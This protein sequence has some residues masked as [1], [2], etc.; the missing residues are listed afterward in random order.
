LQKTFIKIRLYSLAA[1]ASCFVL[2]SITS[3]SF[4]QGRDRSKFQYIIDTSTARKDTTSSK[5]TTAAKQPIDSTAR[6]K[7]FKFVREDIP[8]PSFGTY[9]SPFFLTRTQLVQKTITF[10]SLNNVI[11]S[12]TFDGEQI[13][14]H[15]KIPLDQYLEAKSNFTLRDRMYTIVSE[16]YKIETKDELEKLFKN[17]TDITI[18]LPFTT[19]TIFGPPTINLKINGA[20]DITASYQRNSSDQ[21]TI[22]EVSPTQNNINFKQEVQ[23]TTKGSI[24]DK[25][26]ID[27]D[28]NSQ[29]TFDYE[30]QLKL[31]YTGYPD[32]VIQSLE[33]GN[34][35]LETKS[36][37]IG[38]TQALFGIKGQFKLGPLTLTAI[39]SQK[40]SEKKEVDITGGSQQVNFEIPAYQY[41]DNN[42][43]LDT[44]YRPAFEEYY[45][46]GLLRTQALIYKRIAPDIEVWVQTTI[47]N[48]NRRKAVCWIDLPEKQG[49]YSQKW[50]SQDTGQIDGRKFTGY[51]YKLNPGDFTLHDQ[52]GYI[53]LNVNLPAAPNDAVAVAYR[54]V[55]NTSVQYGDYSADPV[56][57]DSLVL[58]LVRF[59]GL[60]PPTQ[61]TAQRIA[62]NMKIKNIYSVGVRNIRNDP[63]KFSFNVYYKPPSGDNQPNIILR[64]STKSYLQLTKLDLR[65]NGSN[66]DPTGQVPDGAFDFFSGYTIDLTA[67]AV[68]FPTLSP[69]YQTL[70]D[71]GV[72]DSLI[73]IDTTIY[74][75]SKTDAQNSSIKFY[76]GGTA[77]GDASSRYSLG[78][79]VVEGSVKVFN[80]SVQLIQGVDF[81]IDYSTGELVITNAGVL[82]AG[83]NLKIQYE[84]NDL[85]QLASKT[86]LGT[87]LEYAFNKTSYAG[88]TLLNLKQQTLNDK[89]RIGEE[90]TNNTILGFDAST[91]IKTN[92]LT[93][94]M[95]KIPGYN[96]K[97]ESILN[98]KGE[99]AVMLPDPNTKKSIIPGDNGESVAYID[100]FEGSKKIIDLGLNPLA[101]TVSSLPLDSTIISDTAMARRRC[102]FEWFNIVNNVLVTDVYPNRQ[103][104]SSSNNTLT[105]LALNINPYIPGMYSYIDSNKFIS[106]DQGNPRK[107][108]TGIFKYLNTSQTN[109]L[110]ENMGFIEIWM[111]I[112]TLAPTDSAKMLIDLG[113]VTEKIIADP[114]IPFPINPGRSFHTEDKNNNGLLEQDEDNGIDGLSTAEELTATTGDNLGPDPSRDDYSWNQNSTDYSHFNG[115][116]G[117]ST[118]NKRIDS[119]DMNGNGVLDE[120]NNYWEYQ[121]PLNRDTTHNKYITGGGN[122]NWYQYRIPLNDVYKNYGNATTLTNVQYVRVW[123]KGFTQ[124]ASLRIVEISLVG[125]QWQ[126]T[127][128]NDTSYSI[129]VVNIEENP[130]TYMSPVGGNVLRQTDPSSLDPN[131][132]QNEQSMSLDVRK[133]YQGQGKFATKFFNSKPID[134]LNYKILKLFV[135]GEPS[136]RYTDTARFDAS[137][138]IRLG[139]DSSN[140]YEYRAPIHPDQR[141]GQPWNTLNEVSINLADLTQV[142][143]FRDTISSIPKYIRDV[144][145]PPGA[146]YGILGDPTITNITQISLGVINNHNSTIPYPITGSVWF[147]EMRVLKT[148]DKSGYAYNVSAALKV[149][150]FGNLNFSYSKVDPNFHTLEDRFGNRIN[151]NSW[152]FSG[153][154]NLHKVL[155]SLL[156]SWLSLKFK[157]FFTIPFSFDHSESYAKPVYLPNTDIDMETAAQN[158]YNSVIALD[159]NNPNIRTYA[160]YLSDQVRIASQTLTVSNRFAVTGMK[161][162]LPSDNFFVQEML[163]KLEI[164]FYRNSSTERNPVS[165]SRYL[166]DM[167]GSIGMTSELKL[168]DQFN[169]SIGKF[170][171][172]GDDYKNAK[173]YF[174]FPF[175]P[176]MPLFSNNLT[177]G[178]NFTRNHGDEQLR[179]Q[180]QP[181]PTTRNFAANRNFS[182]DWKF[183][184]N[185]IVDLTGNYSFNAGSDLTYLEVTND[186]LRNQRSNSQILKDI[187]FHNALIN[188][189]KDLNYTQAININ[190]K[191]NIPVLKNFADLTTSYRSQYGWTP[192]LSS[193]N[194]GSGVGFSTDFQSSIY[195][196]LKQ[197]FDLFKGSD[198]SNK[199]QGGSN[200]M[201][202]NQE[203]NLT[204]V[205]KLLRTFLPDGLSFTFSQSHTVANGGVSGRAGFANFWTYWGTKENYGPSRLYQLGWVNYPGTR[206]PNV[207]LQDQEGLTNS[208]NI[209]TFINPIFPNNLKINFTYKT[210]W[211]N[212]KQSGYTTDALGNLTDG[213]GNLGVPSTI[214]NVRTITRPS[215]IFGSNIVNNLAKPDPFSMTKADEIANSFEKS[216]VSFPFPS[217]TITLN[218]IER[219]EMFQ[220]FATSISFENSYS[221]DYKKTLQFNGNAPEYIASQSLTSGFTPLIGINVAFKQI[222]GGNLTASFKLNKTNNYDLTP[223]SLVINNTNTTDL[224]IN[225]SYSKSGFKIPL[226]GLS[227]DNDISI[228][229]SYTRTNNDPRTLKYDSGIWSDDAQ[230]SGS[231]STA[232]N[233][234]IQYALSKNVSI[235]VFY[236]YTKIAPTQGSLQIP[237]TTSNEA[238][239][240]IKLTIQ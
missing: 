55:N 20:I 157:D 68:I 185:W 22:T 220:S 111:R 78:F 224:A 129:S 18:P 172:L 176:A 161:F 33:A 28:W 126:K 164:S 41:D 45:Y 162:T 53:S 52:A 66:Y 223:S 67:G 153:T 188:F 35:S 181:N 61:D 13:K 30:N 51:F 217:W 7:Y 137:M 99:V 215:F 76:M 6:I 47:N 4:S 98:L 62:W 127:N 139:S 91:D 237:T 148:N 40:K 80:G 104:G 208:I 123:F 27:A 169:L 106:E 178:A 25:L 92:F 15:L 87:R 133:L 209:N 122:K 201:Y 173:M 155:N 225:A 179:N 44:S 203:Q 72:P 43:F 228:S 54:M 101:W 11:I 57:P 171:P 121:L 240:N 119:E 89:V 229:F 199:M 38:S 163:N 1:V 108:W 211:Q 120:V 34:V 93:R 42:Y 96:S 48:P 3:D 32:E 79:N 58:K 193:T 97:E 109:L 165:Q 131:V 142:K 59:P 103:V 2:F 23:V 94:L 39:A 239:L 65:K 12:E 130:S 146:Y 216:V 63:T 116:E 210:S 144:N 56:A 177:I 174:F 230:T 151:S 167:G 140:Y 124:P 60:L 238:G 196:K 75:N 88:F 5:D 31:K 183:I 37:L 170:L 219:F 14:N 105:P 46:Y 16:F 236:K 71:A 202:Q 197:V 112:D 231:I 235:Q 189:G 21:Q 107:K 187:F 70:K 147:N 100:D 29:R 50:K 9:E 160:Q 166:W 26:T 81:T 213:L 190:P 115:T 49:G 83:S 138:V 17:I 82:S 159:P 214:Y 205:F 180:N 113:V 154:L 86:L 152:D 136:F 118:L 234:S 192:S 10:D 158:K 95:N 168:L 182:L 132:L 212:N 8:N 128:K 175:F 125:N 227:L 77:I 117:N 19:E 204:D 198:Q 233:P 69:F 194:L 200:P 24:G 141:P 145:G 84:S 191:F 156:S 85:F 74:S 36:N 206:V 221:S 143:Q 149:S 150:D 226:F 102:H 114:R 222:E 232:L 186:S 184:E 110:D 135:N 134:L 90:P 218:G 195:I 73:H 64:D 207:Q